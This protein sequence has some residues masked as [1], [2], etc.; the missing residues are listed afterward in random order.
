MREPIRRRPN[1]S[2]SDG[3]LT[4][5]YA[6]RGEDDLIRSRSH[7]GRNHF[8]R[9][10]PRPGRQADQ[11]GAAEPD[12]PSLPAAHQAK[13][14]VHPASIGSPDELSKKTWETGCATPRN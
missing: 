13:P 14:G 4:C 6:G 12:R 7:S 5:V 1:A 3:S 9:L 2:P 10:D 8:P 11:A